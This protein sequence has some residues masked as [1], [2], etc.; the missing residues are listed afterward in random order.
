M[1]SKPRI[2]GEVVTYEGNY[3]VVSCFCVDSGLVHIQ[4]KTNGEMIFVPLTAIR[5]RQSDPLNMQLFSPSG[6]QGMVTFL[7]NLLV[8][9]T[10]DMKK[11]EFFDEDILRDQ[12]IKA[13]QLRAARVIL[14]QE[15]ECL[16]Q[17]LTSPVLKATV[18]N[19]VV[20]AIDPNIDISTNN[21]RVKIMF[22]NF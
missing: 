20:V 9:A 6:C 3:G 12:Q 19:P 1:C 11:S 8:S 21:A 18:T 4:L 22:Y 10:E 14:S 16:H 15:R 17:I 2:G 7:A 13:L 5:T